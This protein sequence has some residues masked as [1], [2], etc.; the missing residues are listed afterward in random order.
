MESDLNCPNHPHCKTLLTCSLCEKGFCEECLQEA[1]GLIFCSPHFKMFKEGKW[2]IANRVS[3]S[4][5]ENSKALLL[6]RKKN[7]NVY[8][9]RW[10]KGKCTEDDI[11]RLEDDYGR[12]RISVLG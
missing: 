4:N 12:G 11:V 6:F 3:C 10:K 2:V 5:D 9:G 7:G 1:D 8:E